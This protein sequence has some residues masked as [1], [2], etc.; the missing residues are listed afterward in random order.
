MVIGFTIGDQQTAPLF[1]GIAVL[2]NFFSYF[3]SD[4]LALKMSGAPADGGTE[5]PEYFQMVRELCQR[6]E[7][8]DAPPLRHSAGAAERFRDRP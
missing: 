5:N 8:P 3:F 7:I 6:A 2:M 4:K 1:L